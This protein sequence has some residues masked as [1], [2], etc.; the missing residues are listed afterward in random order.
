MNNPFLMQMMGGA[1]NASNALDAWGSAKGKGKGPPA[2]VAPKMVLPK[3]QIQGKPASLAMASSANATPLGGCGAF[4]GDYGEYG[5]YGGAGGFP[6]NGGMMVPPKMQF[7]PKAMGLPALGGPKAPGAILPQ[8]AGALM[9]STPKAS[10]SAAPSSWQQWEDNDWSGNSGENWSGPDWSGNSGNDWSGG[11]KKEWNSGSG[12]DWNEWKNDKWKSWSKDE[13]WD[14]WK[15]WGGR[16]KGKG[17]GKRGKDDGQGEESWGRR[18]RWGSDLEVVVRGL[19][20]QTQEQSI[21]DFFA[22]CGE[23]T[24]ITM[25]RSGKMV[26]V[27]FASQEGID[28]AV[29]FNKTFFNGIYI[30]VKSASEKY[31]KRGSNDE[32]TVVVKGFPD[33]AD[34]ATLTSHFAACGEV[35]R[36]KIPRHRDTGNVKGTAFVEMKSEEAFNQALLMDSSVYLGNMLIVRKATDQIEKGAGKGKRDKEKEDEVTVVVKGF[37]TATVEEEA[38]RNAFTVCGQIQRIRLP[39]VG[40]P[41]GTAFVQFS[42]DR[43]SVV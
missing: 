21:R 40:L 20:P 7:P 13:E 23:V 6:A 16:R 25:P 42:T 30:E 22:S 17:K 2:V 31:E 37:P 41:K 24:K 34:E 33:T 28:K 1:P 43:K 11:S 9:S 5:D 29:Q 18:G 19:P 15:D 12:K 39:R 36:V 4:G 32:L 35:V 27:G 3:Q 26:F 10:S 8:G 38:L 14:E